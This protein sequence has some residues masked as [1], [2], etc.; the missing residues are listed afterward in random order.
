M[1]R[2]PPSSIKVGPFQY[3]VQLDSAV[4]TDALAVT[5]TDTLIITLD[6]RM[7]DTRMTT[8]LL[9][10]VLHC[11]TELTGLAEEWSEAKEEAFV[12]RIAPALQTVLQDNPE[13]L[14]YLLGD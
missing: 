11:I 13:L 12:G 5:D 3:V 14:K 9:H 1:T 2:L 10:E 7:P 6:P 8:T 4:P